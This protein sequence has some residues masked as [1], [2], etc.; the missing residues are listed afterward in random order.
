[1]RKVICG[2]TLIPCPKCGSTLVEHDAPLE[3][4][5]IIE[6]HIMFNVRC[7]ACGAKGY[8]ELHWDKES[9]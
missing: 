3:R 2:T 6:K 7:T 5:S 8:I 9:L 4:E 1:M